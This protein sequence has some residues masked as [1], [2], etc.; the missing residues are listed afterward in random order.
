MSDE[1]NSVK[2]IEHFALNRNT[3]TFEL[4]WRTLWSV[5]KCDQQTEK[6]ASFEDVA[7]QKSF[8]D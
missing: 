4:G 3:Q 2:Y 7:S 5:K 1:R 6:Q 8:Q